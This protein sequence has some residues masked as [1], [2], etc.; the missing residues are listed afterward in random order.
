MMCSTGSS[1]MER[2]YLANLREY[3]GAPDLMWNCRG[4]AVGSWPRA[5][6]DSARAPRSVRVFLR[7]HVLILDEPTNNLDVESVVRTS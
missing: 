6:E 4:V 5:Q 1:T 7:P 3:A 2:L